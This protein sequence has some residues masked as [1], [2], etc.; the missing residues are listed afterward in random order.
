MHKYL[1]PLSDPNVQKK[2]R[3]LQADKTVPARFYHLFWDTDPRKLDT[4]KHAHYIIERVLEYGDLA[5]FF[6]IQMLYP[7]RLIIE[8]CEFSR[9]ISAKSK[10]FWFLWFEQDYAY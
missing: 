9:K 8:T 10:N 4:H 7:T 6:W 1:G 3:L 5:A 2:V